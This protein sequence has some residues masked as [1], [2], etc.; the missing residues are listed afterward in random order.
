MRVRK[1]IPLLGLLIAFSGCTTA[2][3]YA[4]SGNDISMTKVSSSGGEA[5][6][7]EHR[8]IFDYTSAI[9]VQELL[10]ER[11]GS[12]HQFE[13]VTVKLKVEVPDFLLNL[14]TFGIAASRSFEISGD[15]IK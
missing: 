2:R 8:L 13:N 10:R 14:V 15:K 6:K 11:Y 9:D 5:F 12:G 3:I 1:Y 4:T 7:I